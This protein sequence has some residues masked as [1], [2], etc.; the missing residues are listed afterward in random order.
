MRHRKHRI[1]LIAIILQTFLTVGAFAVDGDADGNGSV[2]LEDLHRVTYWWM[3][4]VCEELFNGCEGA[5][6]TG[7]QGV[8]D[9]R[10]DLHDFALVA[11]HWLQSDITS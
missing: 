8:P 7:P 3:V 5:D 2:G 6:M 11:E 1:I 4:D 10:V 9:G